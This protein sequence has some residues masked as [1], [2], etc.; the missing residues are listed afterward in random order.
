MTSVN[1]ASIKMVP[2]AASDKPKPPRIVRGNPDRERV[3]YDCERQADAAVKINGA[4]I[5]YAC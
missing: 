3:A 2:T 4:L 1:R 5:E